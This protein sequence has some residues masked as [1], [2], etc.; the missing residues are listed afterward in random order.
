MNLTETGKRNADLKGYDMAMKPEDEQIEPRADHIRKILGDT[1]SLAGLSWAVEE[2]A[3]GSAEMWAQVVANG[4]KHVGTKWTIGALYGTQEILSTAFEAVA[5]LL[6]DML[7]HSF[8]YKST[9]IFKMMPSQR[10]KF[11]EDK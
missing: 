2:F 11:L 10:K 9:A 5:S 6:S 1:E 4:Q 8:S 7:R 3:D